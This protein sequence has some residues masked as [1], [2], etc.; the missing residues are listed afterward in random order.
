MLSHSQMKEVEKFREARSL[1]NNRNE[2]V[3]EETQASLVNE[4]HESCSYG[5]DVDSGSL[6]NLFGGML[7]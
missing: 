1:Q 3:D 7:S 2:T 5:E 4:T 6:S